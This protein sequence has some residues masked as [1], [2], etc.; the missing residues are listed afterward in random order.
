MVKL[1]WINLKQKMPY[2]NS[3]NHV[4]L[5]GIKCTTKLSPSYQREVKLNQVEQPVVSV[6]DFASVWWVGQE[7]QSC[8][9]ERRRR[10]C[11]YGPGQTVRRAVGPL[12]QGGH[13][14][15]SHPRSDAGSATQP[16]P[17]RK[18]V[19]L[20]L[21]SRRSCAHTHTIINNSNMSA[22]IKF[23]QS[24]L[25]TWQVRN[26]CWFPQPPSQLQDALVEWEPKD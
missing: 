13:Q 9:Q 20:F 14:H 25:G 8:I 2:L 7:G 15:Q 4:V 16:R 26:K 12:E 21:A 17:W 5:S 6:V 19:S 18:G 1:V 3:H 24:L 11:L 23:S 22:L 10:D